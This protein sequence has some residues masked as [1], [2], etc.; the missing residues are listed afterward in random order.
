MDNYSSEK[1]FEIDFYTSKRTFEEVLIRLVLLLDLGQIKIEGTKIISITL[2]VSDTIFSFSDFFDPEVY[3]KYMIYY[4]VDYKS[5]RFHT[6]LIEDRSFRICRIM[7]E[8]KPYFDLIYRLHKE[9]T[10]KIGFSVKDS[11]KGW[12]DYFTGAWSFDS[13]PA[14][15]FTNI[16]ISKKTKIEINTDSKFIIKTNELIED[17]IN[18]F[19]KSVNKRFFKLFGI[20]FN[21]ILEFI[22][23]VEKLNYDKM[24]A[25]IDL[26]FPTNILRLDLLLSIMDYPGLDHIDLDNYD[27]FFDEDIL[28]SLLK[29]KKE[30]LINIVFEYKKLSD[31]FKDLDDEYDNN[32]LL[33]EC[34]ARVN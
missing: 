26:F 34:F 12:D 14:F 6:D 3:H 21:H 13:A 24:R 22:D 8:I 1:K 2:D 27:L 31:K 33:S 4:N 29:F 10:E 17:L 30:N 23:S 16:D 25:D 18:K 15:Y 32:N 19:S 28:K 20:D 9:F 11:I 5:I 7:N